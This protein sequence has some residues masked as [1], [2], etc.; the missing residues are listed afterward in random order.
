MDP[1]QV[2]KML[3]ALV[4]AEHQLNDLGESREPVRKRT[5]EYF[6]MLGQLGLAGGGR[7]WRRRFHSLR[8]GLLR[9]RSEDFASKHPTALSYYNQRLPFYRGA[10][11]RV[12][13]DN[14]APDSFNQIPTLDADT[15]EVD[16]DGVSAPG[17]LQVIL[18]GHEDP[19]APYVGRR[20][21]SGTRRRKRTRSRKRTRRQKRSTRVSEADKLSQ[22]YC[23]H[24]QRSKG[25]YARTTKSHRFKYKGNTYSFRTCCAQCARSVQKHPRDYVVSYNKDDRIL[26]LKHSGTGK[27]VQYAK[28]VS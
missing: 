25:K 12:Q 26:G 28:I 3:D 16:T 21:A 20:T 1:T 15:G 5:K 9:F 6:R 24:M 17:I 18:D 10:I 8:K 11:A 2:L 4:H 19:T 7:N 14:V 23:P 13:T 22:K 27:V